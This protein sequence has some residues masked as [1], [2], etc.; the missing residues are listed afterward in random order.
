MLTFS[1]LFC[2][3]HAIIKVL[4][5]ESLGLPKLLLRFP[6]VL[7]SLHLSLLIFSLR[8]LRLLDRGIARV[9]KVV[10]GRQS[11]RRLAAIAGARARAGTV[12]RQDLGD[13]LRFA[14]AAQRHGLLQ[15]SAQP[16]HVHVE[17][18]GVEGLRTVQPACA[19]VPP[20][21]VHGLRERAVDLQRAPVGLRGVGQSR[22]ADA[23][24][25]QDGFRRLLWSAALT[26]KCP[27]ERT[28]LR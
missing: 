5:R 23:V 28:K 4:G 21:V 3:G 13:I 27:L 7:F 14:G 9:V 12:L 22:Q 1:G 10:V 6:L 8:D 25:L 15:R 19:L 18:N 16:R 17:L 20:A 2:S 11:A 26:G 24:A